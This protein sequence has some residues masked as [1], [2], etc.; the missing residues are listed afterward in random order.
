MEAPSIIFVTRYPGLGAGVRS[1]L[2]RAVAS[3]VVVSNAEKAEEEKIGETFEV[4]KI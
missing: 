3:L 1:A 4:V 2:M